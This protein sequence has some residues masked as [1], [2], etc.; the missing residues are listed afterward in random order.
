MGF[1]ARKEIEEKKWH[2]VK[3]GL[4]CALAVLVLV[5]AVFSFIFPPESWRYYLS[6]PNVSKRGEKELRIH[7]L[8]VGQGDCTLIELPDGKVVLIDGG[9]SKRSTKKTILRYLNALD[10]DVI[11][12]L[13]VT[14]TDKDHCGGLTEVFRYKKVLNAYLP[15]TYEEE[16]VY[17]AKV[18][19]AALEEECTTVKSSRAVALSD[20][21]D[22]Y[23]L[24][25]LYPNSVEA[26][27]E[28][29]EDSSVLWLEYAGV[30]ALFCGDADEKVEERLLSFDALSLLP[31]GANMLKNTQILKVAH[32]GSANGT[33]QAFL[34][35]LQ[36][37]VAIISCGEDNPYGHPSKETLLRLERS[38]VEIY[39]TDRV[40]HIVAT[41]QDGNYSISGL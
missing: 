38:G 2:R 1:K 9:D 29:S 18:Y 27:G 17:Y 6:L 22:E 4:F 20:E 36:P 30:R 37:E 34:S 15:H 25:F 32:H 12:H 33:T 11:D 28:Y 21:E 26:T 8:D 41:I 16:D 10:I 35:H 39:R 3:I 40:G 14:H 19:A 24:R 31:M 23:K 7:F 5:V 13:V